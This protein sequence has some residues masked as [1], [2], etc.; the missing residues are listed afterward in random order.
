MTKSKEEII[1]SRDKLYVKLELLMYHIDQIFVDRINNY[2]LSYLISLKNRFQKYVK[3][4]FYLNSLIADI[5][6]AEWK[7]N[8]HNEIDNIIGGKNE[9]IN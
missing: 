3:L 1:Q 7:E 8:L 4:F 9:S 2:D 5:E 6:T